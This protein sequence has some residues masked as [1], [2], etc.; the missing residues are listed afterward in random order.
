M[1]DVAS[2]AYSIIGTQRALN[3]RYEKL[4]IKQ[5]NQSRAAPN[6][7][8]RKPR[9]RCAQRATIFTYWRSEIV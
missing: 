4:T 2:P 5:D 6:S 1:I 8:G 7:V 9:P 3:L